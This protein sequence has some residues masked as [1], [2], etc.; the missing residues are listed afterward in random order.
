MRKSYSESEKQALLKEFDSSS[1]GATSF[2]HRKG[3][4]KSTFWK[5][6]KAAQSKCSNDFIELGTVDYYELVMGNV[7]LRVPRAESA[8]RLAE[9]AQALSC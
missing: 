9:L 8:V 2:C 6:R 5:W 1:E 7:V 4:G 3:L